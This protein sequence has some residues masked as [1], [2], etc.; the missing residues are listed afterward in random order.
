M[1]TTLGSLAENASSSNDNTVGQDDHERDVDKECKEG[2]Q[3]ETQDEQDGEGEDGREGVQGNAS[4]GSSEQTSGSE[5]EDDGAA[6]QREG[7]NS[8]SSPPKSAFSTAK[9][10]DSLMG[11][12]CTYCEREVRVESIGPEQPAGRPQ[13]LTICF[14]DTGA[15]QLIQRSKL[16]VAAK[17]PSGHHLAPLRTAPGQRFLA[18]RCSNKCD[19]ISRSSRRGQ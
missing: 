13:L 16:L 7:S 2:K 12:V 11:A 10:T 19:G 18:P 8:Q 17:R 4:P 9:G 15:R 1:Q 5:R 14:L 3:E 6:S